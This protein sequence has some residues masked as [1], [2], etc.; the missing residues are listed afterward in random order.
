MKRI[1]ELDNDANE[2]DQVETRNDHPLPCNYFDFI[3][4]TSARWY[5]VHFVKVHC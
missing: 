1:K 3:I 5:V 2:Q 4:R